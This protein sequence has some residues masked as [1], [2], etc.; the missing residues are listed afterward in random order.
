MKIMIVSNMYPSK[1]RPDYGVFVENIKN[2]LLE[3]GI[4]VSVVAI[5]KSKNKWMKL[6][7]YLFLFIRIPLVFL[8]KRPN[9][10]YVH[11][12][13]QMAPILLIVK[14]ISPKISIICN[15]HGNDLIPEC[16]KDENFIS[17]THRILEISD[18]IVVPSSYFEEKVKELSLEC[19]II[20]SPS[21]GI[22]REI[23][24]PRDRNLCLK[25]HELPTDCYYVGFASRIEI[26]KGWDIFLEAC[27]MLLEAGYQ[28]KIIMIGSG[29]QKGEAIHRIKSL[30]LEKD[31]FFFDML[32]QVELASLF[33]C[34]DVFCFPTMRES[35]SLGLVGLE[36]MSSG[37]PVIASDNY[38]PTT[39]IKNR[40]N[41]FLF[42][43]GSA[44]DLFNT[45]IEVK[46]LPIDSLNR[47]RNNAFTTLKDYGSEK[48]LESISK[49][50]C[51]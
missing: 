3:N 17:W 40:V 13:A 28:V 35:E 24:R 22:N 10:I 12:P 29:E 45:L 25:K 6:I 36:A 50:F 16:T 34:M 23:F 21:G 30:N 47:I 39:Y 31:I 38:G 15:V 20:I 42:K 32:N 1:K 44:E 43:T 7:K 19:P 46:E 37:V 27:S 26:N 9:I 2:I 11:Y 51:D 14:R 48:V 33:C 41:G 8:I 5:S 4:D 18:K 49:F